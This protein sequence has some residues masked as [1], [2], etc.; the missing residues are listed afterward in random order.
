MS[1][2]WLMR[3]RNTVLQDQ[4]QR[5]ALIMRMPALNMRIQEM[6]ALSV[7]QPFA[8]AIIRGCK[9]REYRSRPT[10]IRGRVLIYACR[11]QSSRN[12]WPYFEQPSDNLVYGALIGSVE[13]VGCTK[14]RNGYAWHLKRPQRFEQAI[15]SGRHPQPVW[16]YP[17]Q[18]PPDKAYRD[19]GKDA[20][21]RRIRI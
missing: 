13:I 18:C 3:T 10:R 8:E 16:F 1:N 2:H 12:P 11:R 7:R 14:T 15:T 9:T 17:F 4:R 6:I 5:S 19:R 21:S 20:A